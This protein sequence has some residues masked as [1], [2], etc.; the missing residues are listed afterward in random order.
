LAEEELLMIRHFDEELKA[1]RKKLLNMAAL[2]ESMIDKATKALEKRKPGLIEEVFIEENEVNG[3]HMEVDDICLKLIALHQ[4]TAVDLRL[5]TSAMKIN[6]ELER[7]GDQAINISENTRHFF[8]YP[9]KVELLYIPQMAE[10]TQTMV[11]DSIGAFVRKDAKLANEV[12]LK[13]DEV[14]Q[15]KQKVF[16]KLITHMTQDTSSIEGLIYLMFISHNLEKIADHTTNIAED[17][18]FLVSG[19]DIRHHPKDSHNP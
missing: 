19:K 13:D 18:V 9:G 8:N 17:V 14:D 4:P 1:L 7:I 6:A 5:I 2:V 15:L 16:K 12:L 11:K 10:I 3:N